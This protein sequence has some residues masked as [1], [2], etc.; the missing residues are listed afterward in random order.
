MCRRRA[1]PHASAACAKASPTSR[2]RHEA[3]RRRQVD[4]GAVAVG[5]RVRVAAA[6]ALTVPYSLVLDSY[7]LSERIW[8]RRIGWPRS[9]G[10]RAR[11]RSLN[12]RAKA[13]D[14]GVF[15][16]R[17]HA[18]RYRCIAPRLPRRGFGLRPPILPSRARPFPQ[19]RR[20]AGDPIIVACTQEAPLFSE[21][22]RDRATRA[23][24]F[25]NIREN[26]GWSK[27]A[28]K[29]AP[30]MAALARGCGRA[31]CPTFR[32]SPSTAR[33]RPDLRTD[34]KAIEAADLLKDHLDV[35]VLISRPENL[36][37]AAHDRVSRG[38]GNDPSRQ[39]LSRRVRACR[40]RLCPA[41]PSS[42]SALTFGSSPQRRDVALRHRPRPVGRHPPVPRIRLARRLSASR[43]AAIRPRSCAR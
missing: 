42:R 20:R 35:T 18:A 28:A 39:G 15:V 38:Q 33:R 14:R 30:K 26:A 9:S 23:I 13:A 1:P 11:I 10:A 21:I 32:S 41:A 16:R 6:I 3:E 19:A 24:G 22:A 43:S 27:D 7:K 37:A 25:V 17:H 8:P 2:K 29:A 34:E 36:A 5:I 12:G 4:F 31:A 40:R